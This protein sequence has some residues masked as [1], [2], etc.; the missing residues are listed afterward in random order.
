MF[1]ENCH[2]PKSKCKTCIIHK[3]DSNGK[4]TGG[5]CIRVN[6]RQHGDVHSHQNRDGEID[7]GVVCAVHRGVSPV[8]D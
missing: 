6:D 1:C 3:E 8:G 4:R 5:V 7:G 2:Q